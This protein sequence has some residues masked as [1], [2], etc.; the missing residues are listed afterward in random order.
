MA[1]IISMCVTH[2]E[3]THLPVLIGVH[4]CALRG[5]M[6]TRAC[7]ASVH[8]QWET[9]EGSTRTGFGWFTP[10]GVLVKLHSP[11][12]LWWPF[13]LMKNSANANDCQAPGRSAC[14]TA[15]ADEAPGRQAGPRHSLIPPSSGAPGSHHSGEKYETSKDT[16]G[17]SSCLPSTFPAH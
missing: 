10:Q 6:H 14:S 1:H 15:L 7:V 9:L 2:L 8:L 5:A 16:G 12:T 11:A 4:I 3:S 17:L 13:F